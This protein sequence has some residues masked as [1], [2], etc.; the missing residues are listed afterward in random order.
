MT[1][2]FDEQIANVAS[3]S[4]HVIKGIRETSDDLA[5]L[6]HPLTVVD[7]LGQSP[8]P[9]VAPESAKGN[10]NASVLST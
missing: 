2:C 1:A 6:L 10:E 9:Y 8:R 5:V 4:R 7:A 3:Y